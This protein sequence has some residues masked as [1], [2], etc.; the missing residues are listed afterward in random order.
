[1]RPGCRLLRSP[2][3]FVLFLCLWGAWFSWPFI[4][5]TFPYDSGAGYLALCCK[6]LLLSGMLVF[7]SHF[8]RLDPSSSETS[9]SIQTGEE[10]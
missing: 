2:V 5:D 6:W 7:T 3:S 8:R 1:M 4:T 9:M 10:G